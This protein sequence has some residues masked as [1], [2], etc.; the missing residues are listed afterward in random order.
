MSH[1]S[2]KWEKTLAYDLM[3]HCC[4][5]PAREYYKAVG[6]WRMRFKLQKMTGNKD[7]EN[8]LIDYDNY[9]KWIAQSPSD[10]RTD[11]EE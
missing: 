5:I 4:D 8:L 1:H 11:T 7:M 2:K 6:L 3:N 10:Q 9:K